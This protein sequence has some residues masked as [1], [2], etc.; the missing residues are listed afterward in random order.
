LRTRR[1]LLIALA[2]LPISVRAQNKTRRVGLLSLA[3]SRQLS[4]VRD[5]L[6]ESGMLVEARS[7]DGKLELLDPLAAELGRTK[8]ELIVAHEWPAVLAARKAMPRIPVV[9]APAGDPA[10]MGATGVT[11]V[12]VEAAPKIL[13]LIREIKTNARRVGL[14]ADAND[15]F[16][17]TF[18]AQLS[19]AAAARIRM[20]VG[21]A[22]VK[23]AREYDAAFAEWDRL[24]L[25]AVIVHSSLS[26]P[27]AVE[28]ARSYRI[29]AIGTSAAFVEAGGLMAYSASAKEVGRRAATFVD[30]ILKGERPAELA[31]AQPK[32]YELA[33][34]LRAARAIELEVPDA[35]LA[36]AD[37]L[38]Q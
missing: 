11:A 18:Q 3:G 37:A 28:L 25:Q 17:R 5:A 27:R 30:R 20:T 9:A 19:K 15:P 34:N 24:Q 33:L 26:R 7:A 32:S 10:A 12:G 1:R 4:Y 14:L 38:L 6:Q 29:P 13:D 31:V 23:S 36:R 2:A 22:L 35:L 8:V 16:T 21:V